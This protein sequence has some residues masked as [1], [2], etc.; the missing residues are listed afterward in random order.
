[1]ELRKDGQKTEGMNLKSLNSDTR[2]LF[3]EN[4]LLALQKAPG[5]FRQL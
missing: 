2:Q 4:S 5:F 3:S 1:M